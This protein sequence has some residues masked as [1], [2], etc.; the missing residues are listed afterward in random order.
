MKHQTMSGQL[1]KRCS[2]RRRAIA[3]AIGASLACR[4]VAQAKA[5]GVGSLSLGRSAQ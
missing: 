5:G 3:V 4:V 1:A 2:E